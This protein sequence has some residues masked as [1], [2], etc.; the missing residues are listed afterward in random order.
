MDMLLDYVVDILSRRVPIEGV[1]VKVDQIINK[2]RLVPVPEDIVEQD[3][4]V[5]T[6]KTLEDGTVQK[7]E[8]EH[9]RNTGEKALVYITIPQVEEEEQINIEVTGENKDE[10]KTKTVKKMVDEDQKDKALAVQGRDIPDLG[11]FWVISQYAAKAYREEFLDY[12]SRTFPD[13]FEENEDQDAITK[14]VNV[15]GQK[16]IDDFIKDNCGEYEKPNLEF[17]KNAHDLD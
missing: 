4:V 8:V 11:N 9:K 3:K 17:P 7:E 6:E 13:F 15:Q 14:A 1:G 5:V 12:I 10:P 16:A 2:I